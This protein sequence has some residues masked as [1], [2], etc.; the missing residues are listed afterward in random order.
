M[1]ASLRIVSKARQFNMVPV[2]LPTGQTY[3]L[4]P[5]PHN[6]IQKAVIEEFLTRFSKGAEILYLGDTSKK[7]LHIDTEK[8]RLLGIAEPSRDMLPDILASDEEQKWLFIIEAV[9]SSN[10]IDRLRHLAL[11]RL[12][13]NAT[14]GCVFVSAFRDLSAFGRFAKAISWETEVWIV[15]EPE[16]MIHFDGGRFLG[17]Y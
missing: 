4:S 2:K 5:G 11:R 12:T 6:E 1:P 17:P 8:L 3:A 13:E 15:D 14:V 16:H 7:V 10:P 9:H